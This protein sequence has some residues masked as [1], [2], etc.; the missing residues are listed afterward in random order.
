MK[1]SDF[2]S[3]KGKERRKSYTS[4]TLGTLE[5]MSYELHFLKLLGTFNDI[6]SFGLLLYELFT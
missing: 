6:W 4:L 3:F 1:L 5:Y 2:C